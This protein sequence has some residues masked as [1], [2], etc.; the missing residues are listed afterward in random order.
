MTGRPQAADAESGSIFRAYFESRPFVDRF[1]VEPHRA[2]DVIIPVIHTN[3]L[4]R[5]NLL[6]LY[7]E[8]PIHTLLIADGGS[9]DSSIEVVK[10]FPR[11]RVL[12]HRAYE[13][14]GYSLRGLI[15]A[16]ET[17][18]FVY[19]H[20]DV[21]LPPGWFDTMASQQET[22][23]WFGSAMEHTVMVQYSN[24][25]G[26]RPWAGSQMGR[27]RVFESGIHAIDD[28][29]VYR[30]EDF[31][32]A[33]IVKRAGGKEGKVGE[34][35]HFHQTIRKPSP[36]ARRITSVRLELE[37]SRSEEV[38]TWMTQAKGIVKYLEPDGEWVRREVANGVHRLIELGELTQEEFE[39]WTSRTNPAWLPHVRRGLLRLRLKKA[40][41]GTERRLRNLL[42][43]T[44]G[45]GTRS[46]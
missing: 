21:Y 2:V 40:L 39:E 11:V 35:F 17:E 4:W 9:T 42:G 22:Y 46:A 34:T 23:D 20:S 31:V 38:R 28:D 5:A 1:A 3:E 30:Q 15:E 43:R 12:D 37:M 44:S 24:D 18:W 41:L 29:Y 36:T 19:V 26:E 6:S 10:T 16:V 25:F 14:L 8:I 33:D 27:K 45:S 7:R 32:L 13:S